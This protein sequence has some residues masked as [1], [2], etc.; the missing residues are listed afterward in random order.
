MWASSLPLA[1]SP[2]M[3]ASQPQHL[4]F[5]ELLAPFPFE[6]A[7]YE[8]GREQEVE[9]HEKGLVDRN[10]K[11]QHCGRD[12]ISLAFTVVPRPFRS[13]GYR[14]VVQDHEDHQQYAEVVDESEAS[15]LH[16]LDPIQGYTRAPCCC[17]RL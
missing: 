2:E 4:L 3:V 11:R 10:E 8:V 1:P 6:R 12:R 9:T 17:H 15:L 16:W 5:Q 14:Q 7:W 13:V